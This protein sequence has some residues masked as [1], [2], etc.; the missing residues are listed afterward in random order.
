LRPSARALRDAALDEFDDPE[1]ERSWAALRPAPKAVH[2]APHINAA[3][4]IPI[5]VVTV[6]ALQ[7]IP[8]GS[9]PANRSQDY[10]L[11]TQSFV[12][13]FRALFPSHAA[14]QLR[15]DFQNGLTDWMGADSSGG[16]DWR[17]DGQVVRPGKIR[18]W[19]P[20]VP[21]RDY[22]FEF[23][24]EIERRALGWAFRASDVH[25]YYATKLTVS[26]V[27]RTTK[28][29]IVRYA[30]LNGRESG[31][32]HLP[33]PVAVRPATL[34]RIKVLVK[35]DRFVTSINDF[36]VDSWRD[37]RLPAGGIGFFAEKG[38]AAAVRW[39]SV[40][41]ADRTVLGRLFSALLTPGL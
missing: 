9:V 18:V 16:P 37:P 31:R 41:N 4:L 5:I 11:P 17:F 14:I 34:Y 8:Q 10:V 25:N 35:G 38:E 33:I 23:Q 7:F 13:G 32:V 26:V 24:G 40:S 22:Q 15:E 3:S 2:S 12:N 19:R 21:L 36:T 1:S 6:V 30:V 27:G 20:S 28:A 39:V 29:D